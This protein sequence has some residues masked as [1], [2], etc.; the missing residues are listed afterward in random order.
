MKREFDSTSLAQAADF[1]LSDY[2]R[3]SPNEEVLLTADLCTDM[4]AVLAVAQ[5]ARVHGAKVCILTIPQLPYQGKLAD[6]HLTEAVSAGLKSCDVWVD[7]TFPYISGSAAHAEALSQGRMRSVN[8]LDLGADGLIRLFG[9]LDFDRL[10]SVQTRLDSFIAAAEG[11]RCRVVNDQGTDVTFVLGKPKAGKLRRQSVPGT[12][13]PPG[14]TVMIP[15]P[16]SVKGKVVVNAVFHEWYARLDEPLTIDVDGLIRSVAGGGSHRKVFEAALRRAS[17]GGLGSI[18]H[19][20]HGFHPR[21]RF[22]G[23]SFNEDIRVRG[24]D[25]IG[26]GTPWWEEGG[27]ENHPDAV[28][29]EHSVYVDEVLVIDHGVLIVPDELSEA[30]EILARS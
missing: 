30:D 1:L 19:F 11:K 10:F 28:C 26:F 3:L 12:T 18:I 13:S 20:S 15:D 8:I 16:A 4:T 24:S 17:A 25:A 2:L 27:G 5:A 23:K 7:F 21:A 14:S 22:T 6:P 9:D 29:I